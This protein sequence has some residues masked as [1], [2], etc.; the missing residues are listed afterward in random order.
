[1][2]DHDAI[3]IGGGPAGL[4]T[5][6]EIA[7]KGFDVRVLEEHERVGEPDHCAGLLS[8]SGLKRLGLNVPDKVIQNTV[9]GAK[10]YAPSGH[11]ITIERGRR[12]AHVIDRRQ[13]D[14]WL[15]TEAMNMGVDITTNAKASEFVR[16]GPYNHKIKIR[17]KIDSELMS[18]AYIIAEGS[19][20]RLSG[21]IGLPTVE[22]SSKYPAFQYEV[23]GVDIDNE[24]VE[25][26]YGR[27][28]APGFF[29]WIIPLGEKRA[30]VGLAS[31][32][33]S[34]LRLDA[35][36]RH[37]NIISK[38]LEG[39]KIDRSLGGIVLVGMPITRMT[40]RNI[41]TV[42]DAAG[43]VK[44]TTGGGVIIG[45]LTAKLAGKIIAEYLICEAETTEIKKYEKQCKSMVFDELRTM[46]FAQRALSSLSD[47]GLDSI[48]KDTANLGLLDV[49]K[50]E[51]DM[52]LQSRVIRKLL[53]DPR[54]VLT[55]LRAIRYINPFL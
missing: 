44:A 49:V 28:V 32:N 8:A 21:S 25:M 2:M 54:M 31:R 51:G 37:H 13:F 30:R 9:S 39:A 14:A 24:M 48:I 7:K 1:M 35:L 26:F 47:K 45:G 6:T 53:T 23:S 19:R 12:E 40:Y 27:N 15:A 20:C 5:A 17:G 4:F 41:I 3:V 29:A 18:H 16:A 33:R 42:G 46:Y 11:S 36:M 52:D 34:K 22:K 10:I 38:R 43:M 55:G 50:S